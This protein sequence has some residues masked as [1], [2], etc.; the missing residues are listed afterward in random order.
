[1]AIILLLLKV[2][3]ALVVNATAISTY[4]IM[5]FSLFVTFI[6]MIVYTNYFYHGFLNNQGLSFATMVSKL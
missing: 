5:I 2:N 1:M 6:E 4:L 3:Y